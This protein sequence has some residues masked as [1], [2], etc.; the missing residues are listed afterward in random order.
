MDRLGEKIQCNPTVKLIKGE[1]YS[2]I[3]MEKI[4]I[5][6]KTPDGY[7]LE[8]YKGQSCSKFCVN[9]T[10]MARITPCLEN[11]KIAKYTGNCEKAFGST[12]LFVFRAIPNATDEE[13][14]Y[15][16]MSTKYIRDLATNSMTGASGRQRADIK[17]ISRIKW[18]FPELK[19]QKKIGSVLGKYDALIDSYKEKAKVM[20]DMA[21][22]IYKEWFIRLRFPGYEKVELKN[23]IPSDWKLLHTSEIG[24][25]VGGGT[26]STEVEEYWYGDIPW[27]TP[28]DLSNNTRVFVRNGETNI[29]DLGLKKSSAKMMP[30]NTVL[31]SSRAPVGYVAIAANSICTNQGFK[32]VV[33]NEDIVLPYYLYFF[34]KNNR[35]LLENY[36]TGATFPELSGSRLKKIK[37]L[38]PEMD[39]QRKFVDR[40]TPYLKMA[41]LCEE[42]V[43]TLVKERDELLT[44]LMS[45]TIS[46][47]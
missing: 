6:F 21:Q 36:A 45:G 34:Y 46:I 44:G 12:E 25:V 11:G 33:C 5:G 17:F 7:G 27:L 20:Q 15:Y 18:D 2:K 30:I 24:D 10:I 40:V 3:D 39:I 23:G 4:R 38:I 14:V 43:I 29:T 22:E 13:Y 32:S 35:D 19:I 41:D 47:C 42:K 37:V 26:P 31:L 28:A 9:D 16:L 1:E 8:E